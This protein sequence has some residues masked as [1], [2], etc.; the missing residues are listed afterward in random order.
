VLASKG[1]KK[2]EAKGGSPAPIA[3]LQRSLIMKKVTKS[4]AFIAF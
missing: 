1:K 4:Y 3:A 2:K